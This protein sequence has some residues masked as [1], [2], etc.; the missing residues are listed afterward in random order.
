MR[1]VDFLE[2]VGKVD[3]KYIEECI[4]YKK[5]NI[6]AWARGIAAVAASV[7]LV[8][9]AVL[10]ARQ[11]RSPVIIDENGFYIED[12]VLTS[13][14]GNETD[15]TLPESVIKVADFAFMDNENAKNIEIV[16]LGASVETVEANAF[17]GLESLVDI[18]VAANNLSFVDSNGL[19]M[20]SDGTILLKYEREGETEF[21]LPK[22]VKIVCAHAVQGTELTDIDFGDS[23]EYIGY[24]A[25]AS[26]HKLKSIYLPDSV[27]FIDEIAF[28]GCGSAVDGYVPE[29]A[30]IAA[31]SFD[32]VPFW[33]TKIAGRMSPAEEVM[34]GLITPSEAIVKSDQV[35]LYKQIEYILASLRGEE[36]E[37]DE[38]AKR[39]YAAVA[40]APPVPEGAVV[41]EDFTLD[42]L[43]YADS[44][45]GGTGIYDIQIMLPAGDNYTIV[46]EAYAYATDA[47]LYWEDV[48]FRITNLYFMQNEV[49]VEN[50]VSAFGWTA[51]FEQDADG[52]YS[53]ITYIHEDGRIIR[54][55]RNN[56]STRPYV[57]TFSPDGT[58]VAVEYKFDGKDCFYVRTLNGDKLMHDL[59]DYNEYLNRYYGEYVGGTL[60][61]ADND[62]IEGENE[63]G[64]FRFNI[65]GYEAT[66]IGE[67]PVS[68]VDLTT[69]CVDQLYLNVAELRE[70]YGELY[71]EGSEHG[72]GQPYYS[73][74]LREF[75]LVFHNWSMYDPLED[76]MIPDEFLIYERGYSVR[77]IAIGDDI[78]IHAEL[79]RGEERNTTATYDMINGS[80][81]V[82]AEFEAQGIAV[83]YIVGGDGTYN[84]HDGDL[85]DE[86]WDAWEAEFL[87][88]PHGEVAAIR[89]ELLK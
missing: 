22:S 75:Y 17:A 55:S 76:D 29:E 70:N 4:T 58:R 7:V 41:P 85:T 50:S 14:T 87:E 37:A 47:E 63:Y 71:L 79:L 62:N 51:I 56:L 44:G 81:H 33:L 52:Y 34:R 31:D 64:L 27:K 73:Q 60:Y 28:A 24:A 88:N 59:Y 39:A 43:T 89:V 9:G 16:R 86:E 13:Y 84:P 61:W 45:W 77:D 49:D 20:S 66:W 26:N 3:G 38:D 80:I 15:I 5:P 8:V 65:Y 57:L 12:G 6:G 48:P 53:G 1:E 18:I 54:D 19:I 82:R 25:F 36:Y 30:Q 46:M 35:V 78:S 40:S 23:L 21:T 72:T 42:D 69:L 32:R 10:V 11:M 68:Y 74:T 83:T 2:A 67:A